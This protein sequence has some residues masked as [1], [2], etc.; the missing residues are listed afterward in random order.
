MTRMTPP[1]TPKRKSPAT[2]E[3]VGSSST[4]RGWWGLGDAGRPGGTERLS[5]CLREQAPSTNGRRIA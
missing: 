1:T 4:A 2:L 3:R 5:V